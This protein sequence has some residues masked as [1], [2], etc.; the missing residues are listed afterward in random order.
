MLEK[1]S[2]NQLAAKGQ[3]QGTDPTTKEM[4]ESETARRAALRG[5]AGIMQA[6]N[7]GVVAFADGS[8]EAIDNPF[9]DEAPES[10]EAAPAPAP[11][12]APA[13]APK[14]APAPSY[15]KTINQYLAAKPEDT[16]GIKDM[17]DI[18]SQQK[19][20]AAL[21]VEGQLARRTDLLKKLGIDPM[22][23]ID[24]QRKE[25]D[26]ELNMSRED[27][28]KAQ[29]MR[30]AQM[31]AAFGSTPGPILK[32]GLTAI[33][34]HIP[35]LLE[36]QKQVRATQKNIR[37]VLS[38]LDRSELEYKMGNVNEAE[39]RHNTA[40]GTLTETSM[41]IQKSIADQHKTQAQI[42]AELQG[43][44]ITGQYG[45]QEAALRRKDSEASA[46]RERLARER[47]E[48]QKRKNADMEHYRVMKSSYDQL[49]TLEREA[50]YQKDEKKK[51]ET[52]AKI[53]ILYGKISEDRAGRYMQR[54]MEPPS[55]ALSDKDLPQSSADAAPSPSTSNTSATAAP[56]LSV[57]QVVDGYK[58]IG[59]NPNDK[60]SWK[61]D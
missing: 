40:V 23:L 2:D 32:A 16:P 58:Y 8:K 47:L 18:Q 6:A 35:D 39:K 50:S 46:E 61:K 51:A 37:K 28:R 45:L 19:K 33:N 44:N 27:A 52:Q 54:G 29:H 4:V 48:E 56:R 34:S 24:K 26:E 60:N 38:D 53:N 55:S 20:E 49:K 7:G 9:K 57:G 21:G 12:A 3:D 31:F 22:A 30:Y 43:R 59:G 13:P 17:I 14:A 15:N 11:K 5:N 41:A 25:A 10:K 36:D 1:L 42:A